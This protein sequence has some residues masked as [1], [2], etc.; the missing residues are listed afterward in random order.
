MKCF[1]LESM[2]IYVLE[3]VHLHGI[4]FSS[5]MSLLIHSKQGHICEIQCT[6]MQI[7][8]TLLWQPGMMNTTRD[9][10]TKTKATNNW[11]VKQSL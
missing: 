3:D 5:G 9:D 2:L 8:I 11:T 10:V 6:I 1:V 7:G 4:A